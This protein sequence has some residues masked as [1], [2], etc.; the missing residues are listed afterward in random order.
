VTGQ[1]VEGGQQELELPELPYRVGPH[2]EI[3]EAHGYA[4]IMHLIDCIRDGKDPIPSG[5]H[6]RHVIEIMEKAYQASREG[7]TLEL[8]TTL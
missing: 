2:R 5:E 3:G 4:D 8:T 7:R 6:A 1:H